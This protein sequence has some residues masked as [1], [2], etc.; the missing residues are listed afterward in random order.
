MASWLEWVLP[1][2]RVIDELGAPE[3]EE[4]GLAIDVMTR[5]HLCERVEEKEFR[6]KTYDIFLAFDAPDRTHGTRE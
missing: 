1:G 2:L 6:E 3:I 4:Q 5:S